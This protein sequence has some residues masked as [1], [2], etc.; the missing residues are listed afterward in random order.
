MDGN[1]WI[2]IRILFVLIIGLVLFIN[3][4]VVG[5]HPKIPPLLLLIIFLQVLADWL[6]GRLPTLITYMGSIVLVA[7]NIAVV[8]LAA[9]DLTRKFR[10]SK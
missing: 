6:E 5:I 9:R 4:P 10:R 1:I 8:I 3:R 7:A 2:I